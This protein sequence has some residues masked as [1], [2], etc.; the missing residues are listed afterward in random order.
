ML[1][2]SAPILLGLFLL[3]VSQQTYAQER[4]EVSGSVTSGGNLSGP[5]PFIN[6]LV[7]DSNRG[8]TTDFDGNYTISVDTDAILV[9]SYVGFKTKEVPV[10]GQTGINVVL[11]EDTAEL[12]EVVVTGYSS[13]EK[14]SIT[15]AISTVT[16]DDL[17]KTHG[18]STV[19]S[20]LAGTIPGV[21]FRMP[22]GRPGASAS[23]QIRNMGNPLY[24]IDGIQQDQGQFNNLSP[25]DIASITVLKDASAAIYGVRAANGVVV[26]TTKRGKKGTR[27]TVNINA[28]TGWQNW[29][30]FPSVVNDSYQYQ[31]G[32]VEAQVNETGTSTISPEELEKYR[33]GTENGYQSFDWKDF[34]IKKNAPLTNINVAAT[35]GSENINYYL[36]FTQLSQQAVLGD[37]WTFKR[38][39]IQSNVD[40]NITDNLQVGVQ[41]NGR[42][43]RRSNPGIPGADDYF[44]PRFA[45]LRNRPFERPYANDNPEYLADIG[46]NETNW[47][48]HNFKVGGYAQ[49]DWR[50]LQTNFSA[51]YN[52]PFV[53]GLKIKGMYSY[54]IADRVTDGHEYTYDAF[55]YD[56]ENDTYN[57]TGGSTNPWRE[58]GTQKIIKNTYQGQINY[59][60]S[61][62][63]HTVEALG[64]VERYDT[65]DFGTFVH[66]VPETN[67]LPLIYFPEIDTYND[68]DNEEARI[69]YIL[70]LN[71]NYKDKYYL[72]FSG[73][74]DASWKFD[75]SKRVGY[76]PGGS[77]GWRIT[78]EPFVQNLLG[79]ESLLNNF[80]LRVSY[81]EL[82][83]DDLGDILGPYDYLTGYNYNQG[84]PAI[85][86]DDAVVPARD[87]GQ[88]VNNISWLKSKIFDIGADMYLFDN[89]LS[90]T[91]DYFYRKR[92]GL[93]QAKYDV[94][95]PSE[96]GY[97]LPLENLSS[98]AQYGFE[99]A[100]A[101]ADKIGELSY[102][103]SGNASV[104]RSKF[105]NSYKPRWNN[106]WDHYRSSGENRYNTIFWGLETIGQFQ[107]EEQIADYEID[108][109]G[110]GNRTMLPGD[111]I[112][113]DLNGDG[114]IDGYDEKPIGYNNFNPLVNFGFSLNLNYKH[115]D[116]TATFSGA[117]GF[118]WN[119][120]YETRWAYQNNGALN[121]IFLDRWR[122]ADPYDASSEWLPGK[123]PPLRY[124]KGG[125]NSYRNSDFWLHNVWYLKSRTLE[126]GYTM[127]KELL[128]KVNI[129]KCRFY[130]NTNNLFRFDNLSQYGV[131]PEVAADNGLEYP[132]NSFVNLGVNLSL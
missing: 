94:L 69:G 2:Q 14:K 129:Q 29:T 110:E 131:D 65:R 103:V 85:F 96:L 92:T 24:V 120:N 25:N 128:N 82:G 117:T 59:K 33:I 132:Q 99:G 68:Y 79:N 10:D 61:F 64:I 30:S 37:E 108:N 48:L 27:S 49:T 75:P 67:T 89:K 15:G 106:S 20:G 115:F 81:G 125:H 130:I 91:F 98:D 86:N 90:A 54:Y 47:G 28:Y 26:V 31:L 11:E 113:N 76:F 17:E 111:L 95:V 53:D 72:E 104:S 84:S 45:I 60:Q 52:I 34:I 112:Y 43:E 56:A 22:D 119:Q 124:N 1:K 63:D 80:K 42:I 16:A 116:F 8:T 126:L 4:I 40:A 13:Q 127:S 7:K 118:S 121:K 55:T 46:H 6:V 88:I 78:E 101:Y 38:S 114:R 39:N 71:Y 93:P 77:A 51:E 102:N 32:V 36:S 41:I 100:L 74:R 66:S 21:S 35:G 57:R 107:S 83:D 19:S 70:R 62:G 97:G 12:D 58:R 5:L 105:L 73:R 44:L 50:V 23:I 109:D 87:K 123:Y 122:H 3:L 9:F 18:G